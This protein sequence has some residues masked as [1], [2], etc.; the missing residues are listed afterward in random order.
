M[1]FKVV[2]RGTDGVRMS[3][4][5]VCVALSSILLGQGSRFARALHSPT[6]ALWEVDIQTS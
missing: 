4:F 1:V 6:R 5:C 3:L 2:I